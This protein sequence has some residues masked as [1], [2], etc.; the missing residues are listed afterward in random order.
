MG[1]PS[2]PDCPSSDPA[3][4]CSSGCPSRCGQLR[5]AVRG[6]RQGQAESLCWSPCAVRR[7]PPVTLTVCPSAR[8]GGPPGSDLSGHMLQSAWASPFSGPG[9]SFPTHRL[10]E[11]TGGSSRSL[12]AFPALPGARCH[13]P[14]ERGT[15]NLREVIAP[16]SVGRIPARWGGLVGARG[17]PPPPQPL[18]G[19][20][21][22]RGRV[23]V[24]GASGQNRLKRGSWRGPGAAGDTA[25][26]LWMPQ[27]LQGGKAGVPPNPQ[28]SP[29]FS[30]AVCAA[31]VSS[32]LCFSPQSG[33]EPLGVQ[34]C[35]A[36][37][38]A[39][40]PTLSLPS[41][42]GPGTEDAPPPPAGLGIGWP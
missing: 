39:H 32:R 17:A 20:G 3:P 31:G 36:R 28:R 21:W 38:L 40:P 8:Q 37:T 26:T 22:E 25:M 1:V 34:S 4:F 13:L 23:Q 12:L 42:A 7:G 35:P 29:S 41:E 2:P 15:S 19:L 27:G 18:L 6:S 5:G 24:R 9:L 16:C 10:G 14:G 33:G 30:G 11:G